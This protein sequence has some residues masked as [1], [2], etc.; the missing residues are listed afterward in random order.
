M[1]GLDERSGLAVDCAA[2]DIEHPRENALA[3]RRLERSAGVFH[4]HAP[5]EALGGGEGNSTY[6]M[7][8]ELGKHLDRNRA[9]MCVQQGVDGRCVRIEPYVDDTS[10]HRD[11]RAEV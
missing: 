11:H 2:E 3:D 1:A 4:C 6:A 8:V 5:R 10:A 7:L 9:L